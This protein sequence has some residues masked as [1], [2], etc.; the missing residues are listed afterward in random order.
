MKKKHFNFGGEIQIQ[1]I[2]ILLQLYQDLFW[3]HVILRY[4]RPFKSGLITQI[5]QIEPLFFSF[6][7]FHSFRTAWVAKKTGQGQEICG[8][9][10]GF[11]F[12]VLNQVNWR[13]L[14][15]LAIVF[16]PLRIYHTHKDSYEKSCLFD[17]TSS[18]SIDCMGQ[19]WC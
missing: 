18:A 5:C 13:L 10:R 2:A 9:S 1:V 4:K 3:T 17:G 19:I 11:F 6:H 7:Y 8:C 12:H 16:L 15:N 14:I